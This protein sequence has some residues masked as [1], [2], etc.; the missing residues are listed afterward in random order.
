MPFSFKRDSLT[1]LDWKIWNTTREKH[2]KSSPKVQSNCSNFISNLEIAFQFLFTF[3]LQCSHFPSNKSILIRIILWFEK[4]ITFQNIPLLQSFTFC[5]LKVTSN[6]GVQ[7]LPYNRVLFFM[8]TSSQQILSISEKFAIYCYYVS[9]LLVFHSSY[10]SRWSCGFNYRA[11]LCARIF[12]CWTSWLA[13]S[14]C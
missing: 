5:E 13:G 14:Y 1:I 4:Q 3:A 6:E 2:N 10:F 8:G 11:A 9:Y 7:L 12:C